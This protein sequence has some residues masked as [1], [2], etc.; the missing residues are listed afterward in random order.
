[1]PQ[2]LFVTTMEQAEPAERLNQ[3]ANAASKRKAAGGGEY[4]AEQCRC[5]ERWHEGGIM[6][7]GMTCSVITGTGPGGAGLVEEA[8]AILF[9]GLKTLHRASWTCANN[10]TGTNSSIGQLEQGKGKNKSVCYPL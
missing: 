4:F 7:W 5:R 10:L 6:A 3:S 2:S 8:C 9:P 1:M